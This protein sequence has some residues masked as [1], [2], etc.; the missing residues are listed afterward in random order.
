MN[1][2]DS[3]EKAE[4][5][6][7]GSEYDFVVNER[8][9][10]DKKFKENFLKKYPY[11]DMSKFYFEHDINKISNISLNTQNIFISTNQHP[12]FQKF[13]KLEET[14]KNYQKENDMIIQENII[15]GKFS[16]AIYFKLSN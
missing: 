13:G 1:V 9:I 4:R 16:Y 2:S 6:Y 5:K 10:L 11:A 8:K 12:T 3:V 14:Y 7:Y 15:I